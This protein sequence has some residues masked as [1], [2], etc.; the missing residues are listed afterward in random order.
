MI[1]GCNESLDSLA[2]AVN[3]RK[4]ARCWFHHLPLTLVLLYGFLLKDM[5]AG[6]V[7]GIL[8]FQGRIITNGAPFNGPGRFKFA[9]V[10]TNSTPITLWSQ[11]GSSVAGSEPIGAI[12]LNLSRGLYSVGLGDLSVAGMSQP[13]VP[14]IFSN[15]S[16]WLRVWFDDE[17]HGSELLVPDERIGA[18]AYALMASTV[19]DGSITSN[20]LAPDALRADRLQ[21]VLNPLNLPGDVALKSVDLLNLSNQLVQ[22][23]STVVQDLRST[24]AEVTNRLSSIDLPGVALASSSPSDP[25]LLG[26]GYLPFYQFPVPDWTSGSSVGEPDACFDFGGGWT[27]ELLLVWGGN[28]GGANNYSGRGAAY[29]PSANVWTSFSEVGSPTPRARPMTAWSGLDFIVWGGYGLTGY[30][31]SGAVYRP[32]VNQWR[33]ISPVSAPSE[34]ERAVAGWTGSRFLVW[35]GR[36]SRGTLASGA[37]YDPVAEVWSPLISSNQPSARYSAGSLSTL[38]RLFIWG[39]GPV[40]AGTRGTGAFLNIDGEGLPVSW[41]GMNTAGAP[42]ARIGHTLAWTGTRLLIWGGQDTL[43]IPLN[44]GASYDPVSD[45]WTALSSLNAPSARSYHSAVWTGSEMVIFGGQSGSKTLGDGAAYDPVADR[46]RPLENGGSPQS[47]SG[48]LTVWTSRELLF[49]GG[50]SSGIPLNALQRVI[51]SP[52]WTLY[53]KP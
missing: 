32:S 15:N 18:S 27:G 13:I 36:N 38:N 7:P 8:H 42:L 45:R 3:S 53:R 49:F 40:V 25:G 39:G 37:L 20:H 4:G 29:S 52:P 6:Q 50:T 17:V 19:P 12:S 26:H 22:S 47:R 28:L 5:E 46:W 1:T 35:G 11:D 10:T 48:S 41:T 44:D 9:L 33:P 16:V 2:S 34:R 24:L 23:F 43:N 21:G 51:P 14:E 30:L 31:A